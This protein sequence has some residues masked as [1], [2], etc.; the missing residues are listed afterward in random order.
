MGHVGVHHLQVGRAGRQ[1]A[2]FHEQVTAQVLV[3]QGVGQP[4][5]V[6][7][8]FYGGRA[9]AFLGIHQKGRAI[10]WGQD[11]FT[12]A[13]GHAAFGIAGFN[14]EL[15][16]SRIDSFHQLIFIEIDLEATGLDAVSFEYGNRVVVG[17]VNAH[18]GHQFHAGA[19][20]LLYF[21]RRK[22]FYPSRIH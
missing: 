4:G 13:Y 14:G 1:T 12:I 9:L 15:L 10:A 5:Q 3:G 2:G 8:V 19:M 16:W 21:L 11:R 18:L 7:I 6:V 20:D 22:K 17:K